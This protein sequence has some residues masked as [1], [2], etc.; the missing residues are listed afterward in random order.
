MIS[1]SLIKQGID[2]II[3]FEWPEIVNGFSDADVTNGDMKFTGNPENNAA[4]RCAVH[5]GQDD[6]RHTDFLIEH[7]GLIDG[8]L[9]GR[10]I[11]NQQDFMG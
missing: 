4:F 9:T 5:F 2:K 6:S 10:G 3:A 11:N 1:I 7:L 8:I